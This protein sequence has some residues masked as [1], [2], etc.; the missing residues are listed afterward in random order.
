MVRQIY[1][2]RKRTVIFAI[3]S[4]YLKKV[5]EDEKVVGQTLTHDRS[6]FV[7]WYSNLKTAQKC[8]E[9]DWADF[10]EAGYYNYIVIERMV[11]GL[12][13]MSGILLDRQ[14]EWW[15]VYDDVKKWVPCS[16][17]KSLKHMIN[18]GLG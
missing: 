8:V 11:E 14:T 13:N 9:E 18:F 3:T 15:Y 17:P 1:M 10:D 5:K 12:Y 4:L 16:K 6:R 7:G 2:K